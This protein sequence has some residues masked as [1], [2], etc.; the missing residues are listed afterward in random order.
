MSCGTERRA[1][2]KWLHRAEHSGKL[3]RALSWDRT[4]AQGM[5]KAGASREGLTELREQ[6]VSIRDSLVV[7]RYGLVGGER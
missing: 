3:P 7:R 5:R 4:L 6:R 1:A 2:D